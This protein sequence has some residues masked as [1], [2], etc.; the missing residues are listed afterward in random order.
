MIFANLQLARASTRQKEIAIRRALGASRGRLLR[1][2]LTESV[3][4]SLIGG[5][6][7]FL[8]ALWGIRLL[9]ALGPARIPH[10]T[11]IP[12]DLTVLAYALVLSLV[13]GILSGLAP[14]LQ[15]TPARPGE[16]LKQG[17]RNSAAS[18]G[19]LRLRKLLTVSEVAL[20]LILLVGAG[21]LIRSFIGLLQVNPGFESK[22]ILTARVD[23]PK[24]SYPEA[25]RQ[26]GFY[27]QVIERIRGL[28]GVTAIGITDE[29]PPAMG[30]H[31]SSF[32][33]EGR[34]PIDDSD[35]SLA[36]QNRLVSPEY[37]RTLGIPLIAGRPFSGADDGSAIPVA[38]INESFAAVFSLTRTLSVNT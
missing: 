10:G 29:L 12:V 22:K 9:T 32:S 37:F 8:L 5:T 15:S 19:G 34:A 36:V 18:E 11:I 28:P 24:Y 17:G 3:L 2:L 23:L 25:T 21:L 30:S 31:N 4:L 20:S 16:S 35:Q 38:L 26:T 13:T 27:T 33:I 14:A 7:G 1:Q 6:L